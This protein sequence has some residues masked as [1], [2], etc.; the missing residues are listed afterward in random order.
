MNTLLKRMLSV[1]KTWFLMYILTQRKNL[2][3][4]EKLGN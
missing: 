4:V 2:D 3:R 1:T